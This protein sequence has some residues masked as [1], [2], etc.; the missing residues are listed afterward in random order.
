MNIVGQYIIN[1]Q[2]KGPVE[3]IEIINNDINL[4]TVL[5]NTILSIFDAENNIIIIRI[6]K[7]YKVYTFIRQMLFP[8]RISINFDEYQLTSIGTYFIK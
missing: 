7:L 3:I 8:S 6:Q 4:R 2:T 5:P 1:N